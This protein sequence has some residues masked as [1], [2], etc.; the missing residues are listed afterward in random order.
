[1]STDTYKGRRYV[2][3]ANDWEETDYR[4]KQNSAVSKLIGKN[5]CT[6]TV[7]V[8]D[9]YNNVDKKLRAESYHALIL[10][11]SDSHMTKERS[12][13]IAFRLNRT[14]D[15]GIVRLRCYRALYGMLELSTQGKII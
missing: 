13:T 12:R 2:V 4:R 1:M 7:V 3:R 14:S 6:L 10:I 5:R 8:V 11:H 9:I 15:S